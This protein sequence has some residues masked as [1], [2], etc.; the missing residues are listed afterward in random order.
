MS[1]QVLEEYDPNRLKVIKELGKGSFGHVELLYHE[2]LKKYL[3]R[4][5]FLIVGNK[6]AMNKRLIEARK[7]AKILARIKHDNIIR[8]FGTTRRENGNFGIVLE[9]APYENLETLLLNDVETTPLSWEIRARFFFELA[10]ALDYLHYQADA[11]RSY[12]HG[13]L[14]PQNVLLGD[15]LT[16]KLAD[17]GATSMAKLTGATTMTF[18]R[19]ITSQHSPYYTAPELL[20]DL[21][22]ERNCSMDVYSYGMTG[23]EILT[24]KEVYS[25]SQV[26]IEVLM[27]K[28]KF[29]GQK[30]DTNFF[31]T[32]ASNLEKNSSDLAIFNELKKIV[33]HC[34]QTE[35]NDRPKISQVK[36]ELNQLT[37][38]LKLKRQKTEQEVFS[39][40]SKLNPHFS[41]VENALVGQNEVLKSPTP[42]YTLKKLSVSISILSIIMAIASR[43]LM[44][45]P[46]PLNSDD[47]CTFLA[48][49]IDNLTKYTFCSKNDT[50]YIETSN[51]FRYNVS[52]DSS[53]RSVVKVND[54]IYLITRGVDTLRAN[55]SDLAKGWDHIEWNNEAKY[56]NHLAFNDAI[57]AAGTKFNAEFFMP[58]EVKFNDPL[59]FESSSAFMYNTTTNHWFELPKMYEERLGNTLVLFNGKICSVGGSTWPIVECFDSSTKD[60]NILSLMKFSLQNA[61]AVELNG[62]LYVIGGAPPYNR[63]AVDDPEY[64]YKQDYLISD[65]VVKYNP[66]SNTWTEVASL[67]YRRKFPF[68]AVCNEKIYVFGKVTDLSII[69]DGSDPINIIEAYDPSKNSWEHVISLSADHNLAKF[70]AVV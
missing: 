70:V 8:V 68:A 29:E 52:V 27:Y 67:L 33:Y 53:F 58:G 10:N 17:F 41:A 50:T 30:P 15:A 39:L 28:I 13:D 12:I 63:F 16:I 54:M 34:W 59:I 26:N 65:S 21:T 5:L 19:D 69:N 40:T 49:N 14:K 36:Q 24:R 35:A 60:K 42:R 18:D 7:E 4:K 51:I 25:G 1:Q 32:I 44:L 31:D 64:N 48:V 46:Q 62:E 66:V 6:K 47:C 43:I 37:Q 61:A 23:Y 22:Q 2:D 9:Y 55:L 20:K 57:F 38:I 56:K 45:Y 11:K 3:V